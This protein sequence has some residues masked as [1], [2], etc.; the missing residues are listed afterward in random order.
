MWLH[1]KQLVQ[2]N[3][4]INI[5]HVSRDFQE[6]GLS[7]IR[8]EPSCTSFLKLYFDDDYNVVTIDVILQQL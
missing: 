3:P 7:W 1:M 4:V 2:K 5:C 8:E 6:L